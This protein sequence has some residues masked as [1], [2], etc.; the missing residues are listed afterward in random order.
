MTINKLSRKSRKLNEDRFIIGKDFYLVIDGA[1][2]LIKTSNINLA[3]QMVSYIKKNITKEKGSLKEKLVIL[4][5]KMY[6]EFNLNSDDSAYLPSASLA[7]VE[8]RNDELVIGTLGDCEVIVKD[9]L[10]TI[11]RFNSSD[12]SKLDNIAINK[13]VEVAKEKKI[14]V[15][16]AR[17]YIQ[18][19]LIK[20]RRLI[21]KPN[22][23]FAYTLN[24]DKLDIKET[25][26][27]NENIKE[28]YLYS[29]GFSQS[30]EHLNVY[31]THEE[32]F[33]KSL[34]LDEEILKI[35]NQSF[36]DPYCDKYPRL[37]KIDDITVIKIE[38]E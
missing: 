35:K 25:I 16:N 12:L 7:Y 15:L 24:L 2:P 27:K 37:K 21:N 20:H 6:K 9:N 10:N 13:Q 1:T 36:L 19:I 31:N 22:G 3:H 33:S 29:D 26:I 11:T 34:D 17:S 38:L 28:I 32:M 5:K 30:F 4:S 18:D 8:R 14:D 23:Y